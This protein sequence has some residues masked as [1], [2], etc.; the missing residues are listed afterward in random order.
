MSRAGRTASSAWPSGLEPVR[1][2]LV[3]Q[4]LAAT[5]IP[6][7]VA[8]AHSVGWP[9]V[10]D[11]WRVI[12]EAATVVG[13]RAGS[14]LLAQGALAAYGESGTLAKMIIAPDA[15]RQ[16]LGS[17]IL[18][19]LLADAERAQIATL[20]LVATPFGRPLY[21]RHEFAPVGE[22]VVMTGSPAID[23][24]GTLAPSIPDEAAPMRVE[25]RFM[26][27][28]RARVLSARLKCAI[29]TAWLPEREL[30]PNGY[31]MATAQGELAL[32]GPVIAATE[33]DARRLA[34]SLFAAVGR[35]VRIDVPG[36]Q[37]T[38]R[39]WLR[40]LGLRELGV[41]AEMA[42][43]ARRLPWQVSERF[44]LIAQAWG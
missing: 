40:S 17:K 31:G 21:E 10:A 13:I 44:A 37:D 43:G 20:G 12:H 18:K 22:V 15:Q 4:Q 19:R 5:D 29:A 42:W 32:V 34:S 26:Q 16:G 11:D 38:F 39:A 7:N 36:E 30:E 33:S 28:S 23:E 41:R 3:I 24:T 27:C 25:R 8:L 6:D 1:D 35:P 9:D 14:T 2:S